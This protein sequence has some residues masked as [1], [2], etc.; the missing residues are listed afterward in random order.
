MNDTYRY[1]IADILSMARTQADISQRELARR[2][3]KSLRTIQTRETGDSPIS[4]SDFLETVHALHLQPFPY[5]MR[6]IHPEQFDGADENTEAR[7]KQ[8][9]DDF[10]H[11]ASP[12]EIDIMYYLL[13]G[14]HGS[15]WLGLVSEWIAN[16][17][18]SMEHRLAVCQTILSNYKLDQMKGLLS[19]PEG[20]Q[21]DLTLLENC[22]SAAFESVLAGAGEYVSKLPGSDAPKE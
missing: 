13:N 18:C 20:I 10:Q 15:L 7:A 12:Y 17:Q 19:D 22:M 11:Y 3:G 5:L 4:L 9:A 1:R 2:L 16:S 8:L 14:H 6:A 21:P